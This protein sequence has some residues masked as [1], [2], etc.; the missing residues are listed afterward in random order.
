MQLNLL[1]FHL[2][3][4]SE[5]FLK[6]LD[7]KALEYSQISIIIVLP[8]CLCG[9]AFNWLKNQLDSNSLNS[10]K[11]TLVVA[12]SPSPSTVDTSFNSN[13]FLVAA[14]KA[15]QNSHSYHSF[16]PIRRKVALESLA[17]TARRVSVRT[18]KLH[19]HVRLQHSQKIPSTT[20]QLASVTSFKQSWAT[21]PY[22]HLCQ[23]HHDRYRRFNSHCKFLLHHLLHLRKRRVYILH[24]QLLRRLRRR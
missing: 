9:S 16:W 20:S 24:Q 18:T 5:G 8:T 21:H 6:R 15:S 3:C 23:Q 1:E 13:I 12:F 2:Y 19:E 7:N 14:R 17:S 4:S 22:M 10:F 11:N